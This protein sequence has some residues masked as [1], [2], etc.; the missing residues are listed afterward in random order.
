MDGKNIPLMFS[1]S[2]QHTDTLKIYFL[3]ASS[4]SHSAMQSLQQGLSSAQ[5]Q[6]TQQI[7]DS[8]S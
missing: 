4:F 3:R 2:L 1:V 8:D 6:A 7:R 5:P